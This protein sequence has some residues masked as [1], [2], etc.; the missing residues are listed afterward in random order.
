MQ[1]QKIEKQLCFGM[2]L[3]IIGFGKDVKKT[4]KGTYCKQLYKLVPASFS[5]GC[6]F[7]HPRCI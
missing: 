1:H 2:F 7:S 6:P 3:C 4:N 5:P